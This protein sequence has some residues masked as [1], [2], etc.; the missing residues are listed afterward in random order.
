MTIFFLFIITFLNMF[1]KISNNVEVLKCPRH[2]I[3]LLSVV[4]NSIDLTV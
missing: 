1:T 4:D 2:L 3:S